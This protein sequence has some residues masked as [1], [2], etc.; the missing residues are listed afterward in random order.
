MDELFFGI[1]S[2]FADA[3]NGLPDASY[4]VANE[5]ETFGCF[6]QVD[7]GGMALGVAYHLHEIG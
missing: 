2:K 5:R 6:A 4:L 3:L 7:L 1:S